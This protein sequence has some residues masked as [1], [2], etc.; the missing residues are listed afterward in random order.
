MTRLEELTAE[1]EEGR[2]WLAN[3]QIEARIH[4]ARFESVLNDRVQRLEAASA[5]VTPEQPPTGGNAQGQP[6]VESET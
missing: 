1:V 3:A 2:Q 4:L 6:L 5:P